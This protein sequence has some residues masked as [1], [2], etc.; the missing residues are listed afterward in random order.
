MLGTAAPPGLRTEEPPET[1]KIMP[2]EL[3]SLRK[4]IS[5]LTDLL[6]VSENDTRMGQLSE[7]ERNGIRSGVIQNFEVTY[8]LSWKLMARWLNTQVGAGIADGV[9][10]RQLFRLAAENRLISDVDQWMRHHEARNAT[11]HIYD[12]RRAEL[13]Y[14]ATRAFSRDARLL[15]ESLEE[16]ND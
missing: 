7:V 3:D 10:R 8:E 16:R 9:T 14:R 4:A 5:S 15:L 12:E 6:A 1:V 2:L 11:S 13:V